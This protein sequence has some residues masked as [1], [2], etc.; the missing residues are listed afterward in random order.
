M[1]MEGD[2]SVTH[3]RVSIDKRFIQNIIKKPDIYTSMRICEKKV[4]NKFLFTVFF[5]CS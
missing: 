1:V 2:G 5:V 4:I 3:K